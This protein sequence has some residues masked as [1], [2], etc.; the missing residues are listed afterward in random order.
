MIFAKYKQ[1]LIVASA[2]SAGSTSPITLAG[3]L[4]QTNMEVLSAIA[5]T[6]MINPGAPVLYSSMNAP[7]DPLTS[8][9]SWGSIET[10]LLTSAYAQMGRF[11]NIPS[12]GPGCVTE[13]KTFDIQNGY[14]RLMTLF[15][16]ATSGINYITCA[17][18]YESSLTEALEL[19][20]I[21]DDLAGIVSRAVKGIEVNEKTIAAEVIREVSQKEKKHYLGHKHSVRNIRKE[22]YV[23]KL[24]DRNRRNIWRKQ[25]SK[26]IFTRAQEKVQEILQSQ[27]GPDLAPDVEKE[28]D[29][30][31]DKIKERTMND[32][33]R[34][35]GM[36]DAKETG[37]S[38]GKDP[39]I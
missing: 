39:E 5:L 18:T 38:Y 8:N 32:Y 28:F 9:V 19:L 17:G 29:A 1:P 23:S 37:I 3:T 15:C 30:Y 21:D 31:L 2:A 10:G 7:M 33:R 22:L 12:R 34:L 24:S 13:S 25:G 16:S 36:E 20:V 4:V 11:Y 35:E 14:E 6:Q 26:D 27:V